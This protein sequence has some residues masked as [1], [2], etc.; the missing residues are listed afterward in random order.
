MSLSEGCHHFDR[1]SRSGQRL[2][3]LPETPRTT[4]RWQSFEPALTDQAGKKQ[5][6]YS[7]KPGDAWLNQGRVFEYIN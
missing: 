3:N 1:L 5:P 4:Q 2:L 7:R 6:T